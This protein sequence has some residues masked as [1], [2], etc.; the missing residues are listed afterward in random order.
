MY[1]YTT[2]GRYDGVYDDR[3][4]CTHKNSWR[5]W[6]F[7]FTGIF[8]FFSFIPCSHLHS[9]SSASMNKL[10]RK[11]LAVQT[12][13][14]VENV[15]SDQI[16]SLCYRC[17]ITNSLVGVSHEKKAVFIL[18]EYKAIIEKSIWW[19]LAHFF[20][21]SFGS[22]IPHLPCALFRAWAWFICVLLFCR[23]LSLSMDKLI[24]RTSH[25][26]NCMMQKYAVQVN[27]LRNY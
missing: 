19:V 26:E 1:C 23:L 16:K 20:S 15:N 2:L 13:F 11:K 12:S 5:R 10:T 4:F 9:H 21:L 14:V 3:Q 17:A 24:K 7:T 8:L 18:R 27:T 6:K 22:H 25:V